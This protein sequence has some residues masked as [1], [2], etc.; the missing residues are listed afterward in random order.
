MPIGQLGAHLH[1]IR[2]ALLPK[3]L[4]LL[5][6]AKSHLGGPDLLLVDAYQTL[7]VHDI[8]IC[9]HHRQTDICLYLPLLRLADREA[10]LG[11]FQIVDS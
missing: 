3:L 11:Y 1:H 2:M 4:L 10:C 6:F 9:L 7:V 5:G 8:V